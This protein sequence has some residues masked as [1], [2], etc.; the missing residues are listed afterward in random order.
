MS[1]QE[2]QRIGSFVPTTNV[3]EIS[4]LQDVDVN[5]P[6]FKDLL[7]RLYQNVNLIS[8]VLNTKDSGI[9]SEQTFVTGSVFYPNPTLVRQG[10]RQVSRV[11]V[12]FGAL[13]AAGTKSVAHGLN[14]GDQWTVVK[15]YGAATNPTAAGNARRFIPIPYVAV[16]TDPGDNLELWADRT[17]VN[18][19]TGGTNYSAFTVTNVVFEYLTI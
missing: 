10:R 9:Y 16:N 11:V 4:R 17:Y 2:F 1:T 8:L 3:W 15:L 13:P 7:V 14:V 6:E 19:S 12:D 5:S 18:I